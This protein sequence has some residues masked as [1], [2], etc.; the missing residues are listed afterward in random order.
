MVSHVNMWNGLPHVNIYPAHVKTFALT[1]I[2]A[3]DRVISRVIVGKG[4]L[5]YVWT[6]INYTHAKFYVL[7]EINLCFNLLHALS[8]RFTSEYGERNIHPHVKINPAQEN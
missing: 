7:S 3:C 8:S 5:Q 1:E 2:R 4:K 6:S